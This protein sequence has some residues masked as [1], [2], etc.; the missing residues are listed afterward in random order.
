MT[1]SGDVEDAKPAHANA[2]EF[3]REDPL[4]IGP[5]VTLCSDHGANGILVGHANHTGNTA[6]DE[7]LLLQLRNADTGD[8]SVPTLQEGKF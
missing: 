7:F 8:A 3:V 6:H 2:D 4:V 1:G 5:A